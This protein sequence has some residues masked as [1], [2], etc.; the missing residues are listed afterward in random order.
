M[1]FI[2]EGSPHGAGLNFRAVPGE[3]DAVPLMD[4]ITVD[5]VPW[6]RHPDRMAVALCLIFGDSIS[7][8]FEISAPGCS[9]PVAAAIENF[10]SPTFCKVFPVNLVPSRI[11][12]GDT[13]INMLAEASTLPSELTGKLRPES[14]EVIDVRMGQEGIGAFANGSEFTIATNAMLAADGKGGAL[15]RILPA[16]GVATAFAED[17][18]A[19]SIAVP[20]RE[21]V[22]NRDGERIGRLLDSVGLEVVWIEQSEEQ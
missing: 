1:K 13:R 15:G 21:P 9:P 4:T 7:G 18:L 10:F 5:A 22:D 12:L 6:T 19:G 16:L 3:Y 14:M 8:A 11:V 2:V 20:I 17:L